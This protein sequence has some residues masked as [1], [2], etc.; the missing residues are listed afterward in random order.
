MKTVATNEA[1]ISTVIKR[2]TIKEKIERVN[3]LYPFDEQLEIIGFYDGSI[4]TEDDVIIDSI[5]ND[6][7]IS[8]EKKQFKITKLYVINNG[9]FEQSIAMNVRCGL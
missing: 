4:E 2:L 9:N 6:T 1:E 5:L 7:R 8:K 3:N